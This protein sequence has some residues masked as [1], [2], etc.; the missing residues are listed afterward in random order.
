MYIINIWCLKLLLS[1]IVD[2]FLLKKM[3]LVLIVLFP[4]E[5]IIF[6]KIKLAY[7]TFV[8]KVSFKKNVD[9]ELKNWLDFLK[10]I[11]FYQI[12]LF[13]I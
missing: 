10:T 9:K 5:N 13:V 1:F 7:V 3:L 8:D 12:C 6:Y 11:A 2:T 4:P